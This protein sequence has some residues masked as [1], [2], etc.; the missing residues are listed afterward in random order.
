[1]RGY[2]SHKFIV[3]LFRLEFVDYRNK[4]DSL[5]R[6]DLI[7]RGQVGEDSTLNVIALRRGKSVHRRIPIFLIANPRTGCQL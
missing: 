1:M 5:C 2:T 3:L 7:D 4:A 6:A